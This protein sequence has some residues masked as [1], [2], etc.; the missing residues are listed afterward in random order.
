MRLYVLESINGATKCI[1]IVAEHR[2]NLMK[3]M[4]FVESS[5]NK[6][7]TIPD[8][9]YEDYSKKRCERLGVP[10]EPYIQKYKIIFECDINHLQEGE[11]FQVEE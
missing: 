8:P 2:G 6:F 1:G 3:M 9:T 10:Y 11:V 4:N 7:E 5:T